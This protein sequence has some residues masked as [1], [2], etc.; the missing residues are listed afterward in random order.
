[1]QPF[2]YGLALIAAPALAGTIRFRNK[3]KGPAQV[4]LGP[5]SRPA[6][7]FE[8]LKKR[9]RRAAW[10]CLQVRIELARISAA[11]DAMLLR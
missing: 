3:R 11:A 6:I 10:L 2:N 5:S 4:L 7:A 9:P 8:K 1:M